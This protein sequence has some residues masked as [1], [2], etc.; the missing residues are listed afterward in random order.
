MDECKPI[1]IP[2]P[3]NGHL[4]LGVEGKRVDQTS[5]QLVDYYL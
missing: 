3:A 4:D 5:Y 1:K 2:T